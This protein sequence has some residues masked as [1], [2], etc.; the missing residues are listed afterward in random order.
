MALVERVG[1]RVVGEALQP[2]GGVFRKQARLGVGQKR[3]A[4]A[5][6][7]VRRRHHQ[8]VDQRPL[9]DAEADDVAVSLRDAT[10]SRVRVYVVHD[11]PARDPRLDR[12]A[13]QKR[14][15]VGPCRADGEG[16]QRVSVV[17][18]RGPDGQS[19]Q[20]KTPFLDWT[21]HLSNWNY[22]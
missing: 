19:V 21:R 10:L 22:P 4:D 16:D 6:S 14:S 20:R 1:G 7:L 18:A 9:G 5:A 3:A 12:V 17:L 2:D 11:S 15:V 8:Q 13:A